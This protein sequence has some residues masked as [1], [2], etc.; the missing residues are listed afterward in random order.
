MINEEEVDAE[1]ERLRKRN[2]RIEAVDREIRVGDT[3]VIDFEGFRDGV[4]L[5][6]ARRAL[7]SRDRFKNIHTG[8]EE[9]LVG[10]KPET[11]LIST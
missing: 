3:A 10:A 5:R 6:A 2:A 9:K 8:F 7:R 4:R 1:I 11:S